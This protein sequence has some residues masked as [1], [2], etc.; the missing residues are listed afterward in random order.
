[1]VAVGVERHGGDEGRDLRQVADAGDLARREAGRLLRRERAHRPGRGGVGDVG[2]AGLGR[3][4]L[5]DLPLLPLALGLLLRERGGL[6]PLPFALEAVGQGDLA[7]ALL[8]GLG[9]G[10][11]AA[12]AADPGRVDRPRL[13]QERSLRGLVRLLDALLEPEEP[14]GEGVGLGVVLLGRDRAA[15][16]LQPCREGGVGRFDLVAHLV[17]GPARVV[18]DP[19]AIVGGLVTLRRDIVELVGPTAAIHHGGE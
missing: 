15:D 3:L 2:P 14:L 16:L 19:G 17:L 13:L 18:T 9:I 6:L 11:H 4:L 5:G 7:D 8:A 1:M 12:V 10:L